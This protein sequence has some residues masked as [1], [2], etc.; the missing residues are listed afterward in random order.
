MNGLG[1]LVSQRPIQNKDVYFFHERTDP[2]ASFG[3]KIIRGFT[4]GTVTATAHLPLCKR[5]ATTASLVIKRYK[6]AT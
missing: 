3:R 4:N 1:H 5:G 6:T 2:T